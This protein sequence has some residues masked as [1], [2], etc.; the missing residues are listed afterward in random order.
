MSE[1]GTLGVV[2]GYRTLCLE[3]RPLSHLVHTRCLFFCLS[4]FWLILLGNLVEWNP[5]RGE[6]D[7]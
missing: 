1:N 6:E 3:S 7:D 2:G 5:N 4:W